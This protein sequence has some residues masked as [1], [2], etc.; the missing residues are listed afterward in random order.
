MRYPIIV[1]FPDSP[2]IK[3]DEENIP[4]G[5]GNRV[6]INCQVGG[7]L[8]KRAAEIQWSWK[9][10]NI[11]PKSFQ[12]VSGEPSPGVNWFFADRQIHASAPE[13]RK[14]TVK[15]SFLNKIS[16]RSASNKLLELTL[17]CWM[18]LQMPV[19]E[20]ILVWQEITWELTSKSF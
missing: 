1:L 3:V 18:M 14:N 17:L 2:M 20:I 5:P 4:S 9:W 13:V 8:Q 19:L 7:E 12:Q 15:K 16:F 10:I 6:S 11:N